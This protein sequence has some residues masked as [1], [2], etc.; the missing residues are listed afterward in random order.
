M[1]QART[2]SSQKETCKSLKHEN[3]YYLKLFL[4]SCF[5]GHIGVFFGLFLGPVLA[6]V[7]FN[8]IIFTI[9]LRVLIKH[10]RRK[11][12]DI[13]SKKNF[14]GMFKTF[15]SVVSIMFMFGLQWLFGAFTI[16]EA[17]EAFQWLF[18]IFSTLQG[19]FL[20]LY[21]C[22]IAQD[23]REEWLKLLSLGC[24]KIKKRKNAYSHVCQTNTKSNNQKNS[25][26]CPTA[27]QD[28][29]NTTLKTNLLSSNTGNST[30][31][32]SRSQS[33]GE[34][35]YSAIEMHRRKNILLA[36]P[37]YIKEETE[38]E[39][40]ISNVKVS[41]PD[42]YDSDEGEEEAKQVD[43][44]LK[45]SKKAVAKTAIEVPPHVIERRFS[46]SHKP[47]TASGVEKT[48]QQTKRSKLVRSQSTSEI[49][50]HVLERKSSLHQK[51]T[52]SAAETHKAPPHVLDIRFD[53]MPTPRPASNPPL[54][55]A[56]FEDTSMEVLAF[57]ITN[58]YDFDF[59]DDDFVELLDLSMLSG[60]DVNDFEEM[61]SHL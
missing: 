49:H 44:P 18:V 3:I 27:S 22:V 40:V 56:H 21:F 13:E 12:E 11:L 24:S 59:D 35:E 31:T 6:L 38:S 36:L 29:C 26:T 34:Q 33:S 8:T 19:L 23:A 15:L 42:S 5:I 55:A 7:L 45:A 14:Q 10:Y 43:I 53:Q 28:N 20:F 47:P 25:S 32:S 48:N 60:E 4:F 50:S 9:V 2:I 57:D 16:A 51:Q 37:S 17:S 30:L 58:H 61:L 54:S 1:E 39:L 41:D 52:A 46:F